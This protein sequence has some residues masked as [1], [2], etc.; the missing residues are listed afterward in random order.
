MPHLEELKQRV[1]DGETAAATTL[2]EAALAAGSSPDAILTEALYPAMGIVGQRMQVHEYFLPD[3][4]LAARA[5]QACAA[6]LQPLLVKNHALKP[7]GTAVACTVAGDL[8]DIG[9]NLVSIM[10]QGAGF[11][12]VDLG[13]NCPAEKV[14]EAVR[15]HEPDVVAMSAMLTTTMLNMKGVIDAL[16]AAGLRDRVH[17]MV[18]GAPLDATF[19]R[20]IG[21]DFYGDDAPTASAHA[22][23]RMGTATR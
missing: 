4:L 14:V 8:H 23:R 16:Q 2:T 13:N 11:A 6:L 3:V 18:G 20:E 17:V 9:K 19:A 7:I 22:R 15:Q 10:L 5:M 1:I 12:V 21:A